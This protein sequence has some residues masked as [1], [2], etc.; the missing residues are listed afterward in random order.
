MKVSVVIPSFNDMRILETID[1]IY[2]QNYDQENIEIVVQDGGSDEGILA[3]IKGKLRSC[4]RLI[5]EGDSGIFDGIN[6]GIKNSSGNMILT[7][8]TDDRISDAN[9][10]NKVKKM[11]D[12]GYNF[13]QCDLCYTDKDWNV[14]RRWPARNF[15]YFNYL[16]GRQFAHFSLFCS[17]ELYEKIGYFNSENP[18]NADYEF[19]HDALKLKGK[20][21]LKS[22]SINSEGV[23]MKIGGNSSRG[24]LKILTSNLIIF[25]YILK[26][27]PLLLPGQF[28]KPFYKIIEFISAKFN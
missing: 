6:K 15:T 28:L 17:P 7:L 10:F 12:L 5:V 21:D 25:K 13:I 2:E 16:L 11:F 1:S 3:G 4:D 18:V 20:I 27:N 9:L 8:G 23:Q 26:S 14:V 19:F 24:I 22:G